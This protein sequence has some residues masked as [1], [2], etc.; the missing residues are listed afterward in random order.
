MYRE[1]QIQ[2]CHFGMGRGYQY[3]LIKNI[4]SKLRKQIT[5]NFTREK[6]LLLVYGFNING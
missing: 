3:Y 4:F 5:K 2:L 6:I 1:N